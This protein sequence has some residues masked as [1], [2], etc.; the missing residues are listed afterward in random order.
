MLSHLRASVRLILC[1]LRYEI[2]SLQEAQLFMGHA[3]RLA[4]PG[5]SCTGR[6]S[7]YQQILLLLF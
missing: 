1:E 5:H 7:E 4:Q 6:H 2:Q 3:V